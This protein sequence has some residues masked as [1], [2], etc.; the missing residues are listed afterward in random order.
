MKYNII[1]LDFN[2]NEF[3]YSISSSLDVIET[4]IFGVP[5]KHSMRIAYIA[6]AIGIELQM[7]SEEIFDLAALA[8]LHDNGATMSILESNRN[9]SL[10]QKLNIVEKGKVHC[11]IGEENIKHFPFLTVVKN[12]ILFH[13]ENYDGTG[14]FGLSGND[15]PLYS[16][17][18]HF[19]DS[20]D[21]NFD[22]N[23]MNSEKIRAYAES[24]VGT[25]FSPEVVEAFQ[26]ISHKDAFWESIDSE[27]IDEQLKEII[28]NFYYRISYTQL[29]EITRVFSNIIDAISVYTQDHSSGLSDRISLMARYYKFDEDLTVKL[30]IASDLHDLGKL[31]ISKKILDKPGPLTQEEFAVIK[32]HPNIARNCLMNITGFEEISL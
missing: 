13:H 14:F 19:A 2:L 9:D 15:I 18:I 17:I 7:S 24:G 30:I 23:M 4:E 31:S 6:C 22:L 26:M 5:T 27:H 1:N 8:L 25:I 3:L 10:K 29:R 16:Q 20:L 32:K 12:S 21:L 11:E 28:P